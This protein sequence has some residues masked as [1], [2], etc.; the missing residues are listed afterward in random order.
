MPALWRLELLGLP[1]STM[2]AFTPRLGCACPADRLL[3]RRGGRSVDQNLAPSVAP[4]SRRAFTP[5]AR[6]L[7]IVRVERKS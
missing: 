7:R 6:S 2:S 4:G 1:V 5:P 3:R